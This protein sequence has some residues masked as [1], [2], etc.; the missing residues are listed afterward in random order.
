MDPVTA[1]LTALT[2]LLQLLVSLGVKK[3]DL[4]GA[5]DAARAE[6]ADREVDAL[7]E[8]KLAATTKG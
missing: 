7:E 3:A 8:A 4:Q 1:G 6:Q 5:L 2:A